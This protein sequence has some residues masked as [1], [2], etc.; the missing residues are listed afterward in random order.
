MSLSS[1]RSGL[2]AGLGGIPGLRVYDHVPD[3]FNEFPAVALRLWGANYTDSTYTFKLLLVSAGW[4]V[5]EA[6]LALHPFLERTGA[7]S[8]REWLCADPN[9][10]TATAG[11]VERKLLN[12]V[13]YMG[14][15]LTV[16]ARD[17]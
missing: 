3:S 1:I 12:G 5:S 14:V 16:V 2:A 15:E 4:S 7:V 17:V 6:E 8:I 13:P 9:C 11:P 10:I